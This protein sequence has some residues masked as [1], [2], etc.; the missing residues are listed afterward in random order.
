MKALRQI[1]VAL[2]IFLIFI[3]ACDTPSNTDTPPPSSN[4]DEVKVLVNLDQLRI[5]KAPG[6]ESDLLGV[7]PLGTTFPYAGEMT[8]FSTQIKLGGVWYDEP[9]VSIYTSAGD[10]AW[11]YGGG[12]MFEGA[13]S[14][15]LAEILLEKRMRAFF[16]SMTDD[17]LTYR[18]QYAQA[19]TSEE[20]AEVFHEGEEIRDRLVDLLEQKIPTAEAEGMPDIFWIERVFPGYV[21]ELVAEGTRY[22]L[23]KDFKQLYTKARQTQGEE[24]DIF[25]DLGLEVYASDSIE[26]FFP[27]WFIQTW[28]YGGH[29][30]LGSGQHND[31]LALADEVTQMTDLFKNDIGIF[32]RELLRDITHPEIT[33]W[34]AQDKIVSELDTI[35]KIK[36]D[37]LSQEDLAVLEARLSQFKEAEKNGIELNIR[38]GL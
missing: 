28:D 14:E 5:R 35:L 20:F 10:T 6:L 25:T 30:L 3:S 38:T 1:W 34:N 13:A 7:A 8:D 26:Y 21:V 2:G 9:W 23:F 31:V 36:Y 11:V 17:L 33:Y 22:F 37:I 24:D 16:G 27:S 15:E 32:K 12:V 18:D 4:K 19:S 29:S